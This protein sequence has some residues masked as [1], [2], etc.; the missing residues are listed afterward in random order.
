MKATFGTFLTVYY[1]HLYWQG[2]DERSFIQLIIQNLKRYNWHTQNY[3]I[4]PAVIGSVAPG[5]YEEAQVHRKPAVLIRGDWD[6]LEKMVGTS[7]EATQEIDSKW[8]SK[9]ALQ[10]HWVEEEVMYHLHAR[11]NI[12]PEDLIKMAESAR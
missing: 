6:Y 12:S 2:A 1:V 10:L 9:M 4:E 7:K 3:R 5:S 11:G 8:D